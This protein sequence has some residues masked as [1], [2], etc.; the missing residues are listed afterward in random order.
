[1]V[2]VVGREV[3]LRDAL[4]TL[5]GKHD[6]AL[7]DCP[8]SLGILTLNAL[9]AADE[10]LIPLQPH[11]LAL[12]GLA[13]LLDTV[14]LV[15]ARI[16]PRLVVCGIVLCLFEAGTRLA[17]EVVDDLRSFLDESRDS[18]VPWSRARVF[19]TVVRR[20]IKLAECPGHGAS[21]FD[22]A[23]KSNGARDYLALADE[24][25][26]P[27]AADAAVQ[28]EDPRAP[29]DPVHPPA[30][31]DRDEP[32]TAPPGVTESAELPTEED[33]SP[34]VPETDATET[35]EDKSITTVA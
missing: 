7:I 12:Q 23:P 1:L 35:V 3:I 11:F 19:K 30:A 2:S 17:G 16:N 33:Q 24:L 25:I 21:I 18:D 28:A 9:S 29:A 32:V 14:S 31:P 4:D 15:Q 5:D 10:V 20:N 27:A 13:K 6:V 8:P 34:A 22:Y 26:D